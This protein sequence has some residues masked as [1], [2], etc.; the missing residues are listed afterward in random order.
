MNRQELWNKMKQYGI[1][2]SKRVDFPPD[3]D[4]KIVIQC[5]QVS[6]KGLVDF[7]LS[8]DSKPAS[9]VARDQEKPIF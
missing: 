3:Q 6:A 8:L 9:S 1:T 7:L 2:Q 4:L 5:A